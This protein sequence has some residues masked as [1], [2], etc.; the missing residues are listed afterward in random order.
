MALLLAA[1]MPLFVVSANAPLLQNWFASTNDPRARDPYFLYAASNTGSLMALL[2]FP[3]LVEPLLDA[4]QQRFAWSAG[5]ALFAGLVVLCGVLLLYRQRRPEAAPATAGATAPPRPSRRDYARWLVLALVPSSLMLAV[6][7]HITIDIAA[8]PLLWVVPLALYLLTYV[9]A[10]AR[11][12]PV[13]RELWS[14]LLIIVSIPALAIAALWTS[15]PAALAL[16]MHLVLLFVGA[17][18]CHG[19]LAA[20][21]PHP[22]YLTGFYLVIALGGA[23][24]GVFNA[25]VAPQIF[26]AV[27]EYPLVIALAFLLRDRAALGRSGRAVTRWVNRGLDVAMVALTAAVMPFFISLPDLEVIEIDRTFFGVHRI[28]VDEE[29]SWLGYF[30]GTTLHNISLAEHPRQPLAYYHDDTGIGRLYLQMAGDPRLDR[31]GVVGLGAGALAARARARQHYSFY[32][33]DPAVVSIARNTD[34]FTYLSGMPHPPTIVL[35]DG[36]LSLAKEPDDEF[37]LIVLDA[38]SSDSIPSHLLTVE[39]FDLYFRKLA[40]DGLLAVHVT[41][42]YIDLGLVIGG[43][44]RDRGLV[45]VD[46]LGAYDVEPA[47]EDGILKARWLVVARD[48]QALGALLAEP[49]WQPLDTPD[50]APV[51]TDSYSNL[52]AIMKWW[53]GDDGRRPCGLHASEV[54]ADFNGDGGVTVVDFLTVLDRSQPWLA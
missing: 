28:A 21:R 33:I 7:Q 11:R 51:W 1:G 31:V 47:H 50:D 25:I 17:M 46:W 48:E 15:L 27:L 13:G 10:F 38:F 20:S 4:G 23:L 9:A 2:A 39:A 18:V 30:N 43:L 52:L 32:E 36:R 29:R 49:S 5:F 6:T 22:R 41:N 44:A 14:R 37:G 53:R 35:G 34:Y 54:L 26:A 3:L 45:S 24:G 16:G 40:P 42:R 19:R 8:V 12:Q